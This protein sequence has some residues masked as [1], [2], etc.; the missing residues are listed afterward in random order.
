MWQVWLKPR[1]KPE[2]HNFFTNLGRNTNILDAKG[3]T[4]STF[5]NE[6]PQTIHATVQNL[7]QDLCNPSLKVH[8]VE[9]H[10]DYNIYTF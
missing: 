4:W 1:F 2:I 3:M 9:S 10:K 6:G 5:H 8:Y 7:A